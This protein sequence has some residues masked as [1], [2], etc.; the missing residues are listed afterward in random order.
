MRKNRL[1]KNF[2]NNLKIENKETEQACCEGLTWKT[3][4]KYLN[5]FKDYI[6]SKNEDKVIDIK[7]IDVTTDKVFNDKHEGD[8]VLNVKNGDS[9][10]NHNISFI[11]NPQSASPVLKT[12][13]LKHK[14]NKKETVKSLRFVLEDD[15]KDNEK[16]NLENKT[17][18]P[19]KY[20][21]S[22]SP[23]NKNKIQRRPHIQF[24]KDVEIKQSVYHSKTNKTFNEQNSIVDKTNYSNLL[25]RSI[26]S[27]TKSKILFNKASD[28]SDKIV[29][30]KSL[31][32]LDDFPCQLN[33][34]KNLEYNINEFTKYNL[35]FNL[36]ETLTIKPE[37]ELD[38]LIIGKY[39]NILTNTDIRVIIILTTRV[40]NLYIIKE[41]DNTL[42]LFKQIDL[43]LVESII[44]SSNVLYIIKSLTGGS[45]EAIRLT[46]TKEHLLKS[47]P[48]IEFNIHHL[49]R[50]A[51]YLAVSIW[52]VV[53][54]LAKRF[55]RVVKIENTDNFLSKLLA[56]ADYMNRIYLH[57]FKSFSQFIFNHVQKFVL[58][59]SLSKDNHELF[60]KEKAKILASQL[61]NDT[62]KDDFIKIDSCA[63]ILS[64]ERR[65]FEFCNHKYSYFKVLIKLDSDILVIVDFFAKIVC[66]IDLTSVYQVYMSR[67][68]IAIYLHNSD[69]ENTGDISKIILF[70]NS[71]DDIERENFK[72]FLKRFQE[73][74]KRPEFKD[75]ISPVT[76]TQDVI[77]TTNDN[78][79]LYSLSKNNKYQGDVKISKVLKKIIDSHSKK[80]KILNFCCGSKKKTNNNLRENNKICLIF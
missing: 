52:R 45:I 71:Q 60:E 34:F 21:S 61:Y 62:V 3:T 40:L 73:M 38:C 46:I 9:K 15:K 55:I 68:V 28:G 27:T 37:E 67:L 51:F 8:S 59:R 77:L 47:K 78:T 50:E 74:R 7:S 20:R 57:L 35:F 53:F 10:V 17:N 30:I 76:T 24:S 42:K 12:S 69:F 48:E 43:S 18:F 44:I 41:K 75:K 63:F 72:M 14:I 65:N 54:I 1:S 4:K 26:L 39:Y 22:S 31:I 58:I 2:K 29:D 16:V 32:E 5:N 33:D 19:E 23:V 64:N 56:E 49:T 13:N 79:P 70:N 11:S 80:A 25:S 36:A 6:G 66:F